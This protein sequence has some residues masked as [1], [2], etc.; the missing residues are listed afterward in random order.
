[1][2]FFSPLGVVLTKAGSG[3]AAAAFSGLAFFSS[4][5]AGAALVFSAAA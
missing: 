5:A 1:M 4:L 3:A 2:S